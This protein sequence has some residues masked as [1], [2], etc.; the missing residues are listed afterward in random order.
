KISLSK[1]AAP[2]L[3]NT[4]FPFFPGK[5]A[6]AGCN[7]IR[8]PAETITIIKSKVSGSLRAVIVVTTAFISA[9]TI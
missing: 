1:G 3:E 4:I 8:E 6:D 2:I 9:W 5:V 7:W